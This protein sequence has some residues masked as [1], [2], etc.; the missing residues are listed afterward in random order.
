MLWYIAAD[1]FH[2]PDELQSW[3]DDNQDCIRINNLC[4]LK[5]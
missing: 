3:Q 4:L 5:V 1:I 2:L